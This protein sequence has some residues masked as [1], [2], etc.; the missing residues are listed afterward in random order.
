VR[1]AADAYDAEQIAIDTRTE[2][3]RGVME[4][5]KIEERNL[6]KDRDKWRALVNTV[7][8]LRVT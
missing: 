2:R 3:L 7:M 1:G 4:N 5:S 8:K 6:W